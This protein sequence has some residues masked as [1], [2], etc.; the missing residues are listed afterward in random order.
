MRYQISK[1]K[2]PAREIEV[3][4][5]EIEKINKEWLEGENIF[6]NVKING[7]MT[8]T[9]G[10]VK[11]VIGE[12]KNFNISI[13]YR[14]WKEFGMEATIGT[15]RHEFAHV[16]NLAMNGDF[17]TGHNESFKEIC[18][19]IG[20]VMNREHAG[21]KYKDCLTDDYVARKPK[22]TLVCPKCGYHIGR[23]RLTKNF[24]YGRIC[25]CGTMVSKFERIQNY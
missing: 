3:I 5:D 1:G 15:L 16:I 10:H 9:N 20:G 13:S 25:K 21:E 24:L 12:Y 8:K 19:E 11:Y 23:H 2:M 17:G 18:R 14:L 22:W 7:K 6:V 4:R